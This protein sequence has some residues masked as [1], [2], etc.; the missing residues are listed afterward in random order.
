[1]EPYKWYVNNVILFYLVLKNI[2]VDLFKLI[3]NCE[4]I[5]DD[6]QKQVMICS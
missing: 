5:L 3:I 4:T 2:Y 6:L 1:M